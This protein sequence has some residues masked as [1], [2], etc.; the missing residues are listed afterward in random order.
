MPPA[1]VVS[2]TIAV[3]AARDRARSLARAAFP[4]RRCRLILARTSAD[5]ERAFR[6]SLVDAAVVDCA[7]PNDDTWRAVALAREFPSAPFFALTPFRPTDGP[8]VARCAACDVA[9]ILVESVDDA[10][11]RDLVLPR[12]FTARFAAALREPPAGL[13]IDSTLQ[14]DTWRYL[15]GHGGRTVRTARIAGALG[16]TREHLSRA[17]SADGVPNLKRMIDLVRIIAAAELAKNPGYDVADVARVLEFASSSHLSTT[18]QRVTGTRPVSLARLRGLDLIA[19][20]CRGRTR[21]R[22]GTR[23]AAGTRR[24]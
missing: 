19:R 5:L 21:S 18:A 1:T 14:R 20:F 2:L 16:V 17:F 24:A 10:S 8:V 9:D 13:G 11:L 4:R 3:V 23:Q 12:A 15:V 7:A 22:T 6:D